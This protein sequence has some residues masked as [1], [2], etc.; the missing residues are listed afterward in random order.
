MLFISVSRITV[1]RR[2]C[3]PKTAKLAVNT[4]LRVVVEE[5]LAAWWS[6]QQ[7]SGWLTDTYLGVEEMRVSHETIYLSLFVQGKGALGHELTRCLRTGRA[8]PTSH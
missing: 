8:I 2:A 4:R 3:R 5:K 1:G 6:P 7:I